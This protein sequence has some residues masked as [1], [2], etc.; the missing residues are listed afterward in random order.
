ML[1][2]V[3][4]RAKLPLLIFSQKQVIQKLPSN[5]FASNF[6]RFW[7]HNDVYGPKHLC[8][9]RLSNG[10]RY[11]GS[12][13]R[14]FRKNTIQTEIE[15]GATFRNND[16]GFHSG[17]FEWWIAHIRSSTNDFFTMLC[18]DADGY[19]RKIVER[20]PIRP[21]ICSRNGRCLGM[22]IYGI[23]FADSTE[24]TDRR[25]NTSFDKD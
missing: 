21:T 3:F 19:R 9:Q 8:G 12:S 13:Y 25:L 22:H 10:K 7:I 2:Y 15:V 24:I 5:D 23:Y 17:L 11:C 16:W 18:S 1:D 4:R 6:W 20:I 14:Y